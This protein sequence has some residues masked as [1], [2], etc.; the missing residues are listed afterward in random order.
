[1]ASAGL[2]AA[3]SFAQDV[4]APPVVFQSG[5]GDASLTPPVYVKP[6]RAEISCDMLGLS[7]KAIENGFTAQLM[8]KVTPM[9]FQC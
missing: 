8:N 9:P 3:P 7:S 5:T 6:P 1:M 2:F 4:S